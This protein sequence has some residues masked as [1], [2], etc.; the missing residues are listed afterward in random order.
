M[1]KSILLV[2]LT[3]VLVLTGCTGGEK[4]LTEEEQAAERGYTIEEYREVKDAAARMNMTI[5][6]HESMDMDEE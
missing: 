1:K 2:S 3:L 6:E 4:A 5:D